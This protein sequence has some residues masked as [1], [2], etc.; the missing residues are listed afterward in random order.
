MLSRRA[1]WNVSTNALTIARERALAA[2][3]ALIDLTASNPTTAGI[4]Y[5]LD[6]I[7]EALARGARTAYD[8]QP[9]GIAKAREA[10]ARST[11]VDAADVVI[12]ASTS[13]AY[14]FLFK[15][16][17]DP[18]DEILTPTPS[19]PLL[20]HLAE[21]E[22]LRLAHFPLEFHGR[23]HLDA[24]RFR[25]SVTP[26]TRAV[27]VVSPNNPTGAFITGGDFDTLAESGLPLISDEVFFDYPIARPP[28]AASLR[29]ED[30]LAFALGG[31]S[32]SAGLPHLKLGWIIV[33]GPREERARAVSA[34]ELIADNFLSV[35]TPVQEALP[36]L[37]AIA[38]QIR[39]AILERV[40]GNL[41]A[42]REAARAFPSVQV[43]PV[44]GGW[45]A[46]LRVPKLVSDE[47]LA[48]RLLED[49]GVIVHPG[50]FFDFDREGFL[51][52]S[53]LPPRDEFRRGVAALL[54]HLAQ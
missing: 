4:P 29:R 1:D 6:A 25:E 42:L 22:Q 48:I 21:L 10:V 51:A 13:E 32:K 5:P 47:E 36:D 19:Y 23:W 43:L 3:R 15:L 7:A 34:L 12:T 9:L 44:E 31:L 35:S 52:L 28:D 46:V 49:A 27:V 2:G 38:P 45:T 30:V 40:I 20:Q 24:S 17:G 14:S 41:G 53:L 16:L 54:A 18:G 39:A 26:R 33:S 8:P 37:L 11:G 50:Y